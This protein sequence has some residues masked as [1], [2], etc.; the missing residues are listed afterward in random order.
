MPRLVYPLRMYQRNHQITASLL[1]Q[2]GVT[3]LFL[4]ISRPLI[5]FKNRITCVIHLYSISLRYLNA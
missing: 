3:I 2:V 1:H 5:S 4:I